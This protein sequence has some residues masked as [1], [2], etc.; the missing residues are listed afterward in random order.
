MSDLD[1]TPRR[2]TVEAEILSRVAT[3]VRTATRLANRA[4]GTDLRS[5]WLD[6][7]SD[8]VTAAGYL[9]DV[10][11]APGTAS[12]D[13]RTADPP[14]VA[15]LAALMEAATA[16][17]EAGGRRDHRA[18]LVRAALADAIATARRSQR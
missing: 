15:A 18:V 12:D 17:D 2:P 16:L 13:A 4:A 11:D 8:C 9:T 5:P 14:A 6:V 7:V 1:P 3:L 10:P